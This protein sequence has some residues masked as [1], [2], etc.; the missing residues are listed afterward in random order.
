MLQMNMAEHVAATKVATDGHTFNI[1]VT[2]ETSSR[3]HPLNSLPSLWILQAD[4]Q[5]FALGED[6]WFPG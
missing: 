6:P 1:S 4:W 3:D 5:M 2:L